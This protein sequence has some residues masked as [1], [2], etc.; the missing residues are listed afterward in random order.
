MFK[1]CSWYAHYTNHTAKV[2]AVFNLAAQTA[3][4]DVLMTGSNMAFGYDD[5]EATASGL[6]WFPQP[7]DTNPTTLVGLP[8]HNA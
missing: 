3:T 5:W 8:I 6:L 7:F 1:N 2:N 4:C